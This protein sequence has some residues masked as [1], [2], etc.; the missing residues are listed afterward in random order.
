MMA[1]GRSQ[2]TANLNPYGHRWF[3]SIYALKVFHAFHGVVVAQQIVIL[4]VWIRIPMIGLFFVIY[5]KRGI[6]GNGIS[7]VFNRNRK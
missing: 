6:H 1:S 5:N 4:L 7:T 2:Q 3:E